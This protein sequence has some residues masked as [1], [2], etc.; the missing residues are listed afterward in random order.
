MFVG[1]A[2]APAGGQTFTVSITDGIMMLDPSASDQQHTLSE[3]MLLD[4]LRTSDLHRVL[5]DPMFLYDEISERRINRFVAAADQL[6]MSDARYF[7]LLLAR[8]DMLMMGD[9]SAQDLL[10]AGGQTFTRAA[11]DGLLMED[12]RFFDFLIARLSSLF[13]YDTVATQTTIPGQ[14][15]NTVALTDGLLLDDR[16]LSDLALA[17]VSRMLLADTAYVGAEKAREALDGLLMYALPRALTLE[18][19]RA[20]TALLNDY[21]TQARSILWAEGLLF[22]ESQA[23]ALIGTLIAYLVYARLRGVE[24]M[25]I[26]LA[27][28]DYLGRRIGSTKWRMDL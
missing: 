20:D 6:L 11:L 21:V 19:T 23:T 24:F 26:R 4:P 13:L 10:G 18:L 8:I 3:A 27:F 14:V 15:I 22:S 9:T 2:G 17:L 12:G 5:L 25:G 7:D 28:K 1:T 16:R